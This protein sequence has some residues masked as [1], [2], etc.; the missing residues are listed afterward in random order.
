MV[1]L[2]NS[3][4]INLASW[5]VKGSFVSSSLLFILVRGKVW[6][7]KEN[8]H[9]RVRLNQG[10]GVPR[11]ELQSDQACGR[12]GLQGFEHW[13]RIPMVRIPVESGNWTQPLIPTTR[14]NHYALLSVLLRLRQGRAHQV[15]RL[16]LQRLRSEGGWRQMRGWAE[17][18]SRGGVRQRGEVRWRVVHRT[19]DTG[20]SLQYS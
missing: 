15:C 11:R 12:G 4:Q 14:L 1:D 3:I 7:E 19:L 10:N 8:P 18:L 20:M 13:M 9:G 17:V 16:R 2:K 6:S 5:R